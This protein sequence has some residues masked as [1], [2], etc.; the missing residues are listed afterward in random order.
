MS[1][2]EEFGDRLES[3]SHSLQNETAAL[4]VILKDEEAY[5]DEFVDYHHALGFSMIFIY[6]NTDTFEMKQWAIEKGNFIH[7][8]SWPGEA[9]QILLAY[10]DCARTAYAQGYTWAAFFDADEILILKKHDNVVSFLRDHR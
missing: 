2:I 1:Y 3:T 8:V 9:Q 4:C 7:A 6:D 10:R 5:V